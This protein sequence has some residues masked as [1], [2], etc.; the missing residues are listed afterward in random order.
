MSFDLTVFEPGAPPPDRAGFLHWFNQQTEWGEEHGYNNPDVCSPALRAWFDEMRQTYPPMNGPFASDDYDNPKL[1]DYSVGRTM[2]CA[3]FAWSQAE[4]AYAL[5]FS[6]ARKHRVGFYYT[7][8]DDGEVWMPVANGEYECVHGTSAEPGTV[9][10]YTIDLIKKD[11][12][13]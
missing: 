8:A 11:D 10:T 5:M 4:D 7:S 9:R 1:S 6:L 2:I 3:S 13:A 12:Q